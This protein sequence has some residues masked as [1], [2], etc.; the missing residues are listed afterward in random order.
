MV[1]VSLLVALILLQVGV[2]P[3][4]DAYDGRALHVDDT[5]HQRV[6]LVVRLRDQQTA[7]LADAEP[8]PAGQDTRQAGPLERLLEAIKV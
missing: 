7:V 2:L 8:D 1:D 5:V 6:V 3:H 4:V